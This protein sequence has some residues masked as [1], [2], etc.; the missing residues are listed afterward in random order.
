MSKSHK[1]WKNPLKG[2][3]MDEVYGKEKAAIWKKN[4]SKGSFGIS[5]PIKGK[6]YDE[7]YGKNK[8]LKWKE[9][10]K[11]TFAQPKVKQKMRSSAWKRISNKFGQVAPNYNLEACS[12]FEGLNKKYNW[13]GNH[14]ENG[15]EYYIE[16]LG[17][18]VDYYEPSLNLVIEWD[19]AYHVRQK[20][21]DKV[22]QGEIEN[23]LGCLFLRTTP[24][25]ANI[26]FIGTILHGYYS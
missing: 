5:N 12:F 18:W 24:K 13:K 22:R 4:C 21:K 25:D 19:E 2:K 1:G 10:L 26:A 14:A 8:A 20:D 3:T 11:K 7:V 9:N 17:Y 23:Y 6:R 16:E 15:G